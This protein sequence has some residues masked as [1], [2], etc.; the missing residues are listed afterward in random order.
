MAVKILN[1]A[2]LAGQANEILKEEERLGELKIE[3]IERDSIKQKRKEE[4]MQALR[5]KADLHWSS[6]EWDSV[7]VCYEILLKLDS[8][9]V[10]N[11][12]EFADFLTEQNQH[13]KATNF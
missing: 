6:F 3:I 10:E 12:W 11:L 4:V 2:N 1:D 7:K 9:N 13:D 5:F 8:T